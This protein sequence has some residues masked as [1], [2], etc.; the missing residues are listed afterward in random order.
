MAELS[1]GAGASRLVRKDIIVV[2]S[3]GN[4]GANGLYASGA[5][6]SARVID[7]ASFE[8]TCANSP[9]TVTPDGRRIGY[10]TTTGSPNA[11]MTGTS[12]LARTGTATSTADAC[13]AL[14]A[15]SLAGE[16]P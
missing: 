13:A 12:T 9:F 14:P 6:A 3:A 5:P 2:A 1:D 10:T 15:G 4:D 11:P 8:N 16:S 7:V